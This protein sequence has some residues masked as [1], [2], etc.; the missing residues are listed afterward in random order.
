MLM[1]PSDESEEEAFER[2]NAP[3]EEAARNAHHTYT[4]QGLRL[5]FVLLKERTPAHVS[6]KTAS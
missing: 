2:H 3:A 6:S 1:E 5:L 4:R